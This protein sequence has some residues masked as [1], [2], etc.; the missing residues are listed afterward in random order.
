MHLA[1]ILS[2]YPKPSETFIAREVE[3]LRARG[4]QI[5]LFSLFSRG[6][7]LIDDV[8]YG[9]PTRMARA[10]GKLGGS[11][12]R[13]S[14]GLRWQTHFI[15]QRIDAVVAHFGS[16]PATVA[17]EAAGELPLL[18]SLHARDIYV[19]NKHLPDNIAAARAIVTCTHANLVYLREH[20]PQQAKRI[21]MIY[22]GLPADWLAV[23]PPER[24]RSPEEPLRLLAVGRL[25]E[26]KG[27]AVL[28]K[29]CA[30]LKKQNIPFHARIIGDGPLRRKLEKQW[31]RAQLEDEI[32]LH[33]W[34]SAQ[35]VRAAYA[36]ADIFCCPSVVAPDGDR[37]GLPNVLTEAMSTGLAVVGSRLSGIP[38]AVEDGVSGLLVSP[39]NPEEL[40]ATLAR[41]ADPALR[42]RLGVNAARYVREHFDG[43]HWLGQLEY[44]LQHCAESAPKNRK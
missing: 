29:A 24:Q 37:D 42:R 20:Y 18:I 17:V 8:T 30:L 28:L 16:L 6:S 21:H 32:R 10:A 22:H 25:V 4:H 36:W 23:P 3:G 13:R 34:A 19:D 1:Y 11:A 12:A 33:G 27:F 41:C 7:D 43:E 5:T 14:L 2:T 15:A 31:W 44:L 9:W 35:E 38:E 40:A 39:G 26:K